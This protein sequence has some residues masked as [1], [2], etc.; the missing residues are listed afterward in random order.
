[1][2]DKPI[3]LTYE[4][5]PIEDLILYGGIDCIVTSELASRLL[6]EITARPN[7]KQFKSDVVTGTQ[8]KELVQV[9]SIWSSYQ[10]YTVSALEFIIDLEL[11]GFKYD[12]ELNK[13][14]KERMETELRELDSVIFAG[15]GKEINLNSGAVL[16][17]FLYVEK[18]YT[19][20]SRTKTGEPST[21]GDAIKEIAKDHPEEPWLMVLA[22]RNDIRSL[23]NTFVS[24]Y[25]ENFVK[26]DGRIH[27]T[28]NLH[29]T[30]SFRISG[31]EPNLT[32][33]AN[34]KHGY[35]LR[36]LYTVEEFYCLIAAD[37]S[38]AEVKILGALCKDEKLLQ[39]IR[40]GKDF[41]SYSASEMHG[42]D[43]EVFI[44][45]LDNKGHELFK[46]YKA[47]RQGSKALTF[48]ILFGSSP[49]G[50]A[51]NLG[52]SEEEAL[53]LIDLYFGN[54]PGI[55][56]YVEDTHAMALANAYV[57]GPF[58]QRK[59]LY[60]ALPVF[61]GTAVHNGAMRLAQNV[62]VQNTASTFGLVNFTNLNTAIR[63]IGGRGICTVNTC[64][65]R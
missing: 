4:D 30:G 40:E 23:Y 43:Y 65:P 34:P 64:G 8:T 53:R 55:K 22:K 11:N 5:Y 31:E 3:Y 37:Y 45:V 47:Y 13:Q 36:T 18:G 10:D 56:K 17:E 7:Y 25:V 9:G 52:I 54:F 35:N 2:A 38:S 57:Y 62:R 21:D 6:P 12:V 42:I 41:H 48:G 15:I 59:M 32:Q 58:N 26:R 29:G 20:K 39:A 24:T 33:L 28:Y 50:I 46:K 44:A 19:I 63:P 61:K 1:M 51:F 14:I 16:G 49:R 60:G 27:P